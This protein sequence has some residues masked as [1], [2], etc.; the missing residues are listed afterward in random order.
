MSDKDVAEVARAWNYASNA[1]NASKKTVDA[2]GT[3]EIV[4][5]LKRYMGA[6]SSWADHEVVKRHP[7]L[8]RELERK[9]RPKMPRSWKRNPTSW[10]STH[11]I[12]RVMEQYDY[13]SDFKFLGVHPRNF[14]QKIFVNSCLAG[15]DVCE[16]RF[17][18]F[19]RDGVKS[20]GIVF[21]MDR[22]DQAGSHWVACF[23]SL[24]PGRKM[25]G[26]YYYDSIA[27]PP[28]P[29]IATW[30]LD[31]K[32]TFEKFMRFGRF[33]THNNKTFE[34]AYNHERRQFR[35]S[36]CG[37]FAMTFLETAMEYEGTFQELSREMGGDEDMI[38]LRRV[39]YR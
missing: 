10:L 29:E 12:E 30:M 33:D 4:A 3:D 1:S 9:F 36:E 8:R 16:P 22:H 37:M 35:N 13:K 19:A 27:R 18:K 31:V 34:V 7:S 14:T 15:K 5:Q 26:A 21:N 25:Y 17:E 20:L 11:D 28:P 39:L 2:T 38:R 32:A 24:D 23:V 6:E